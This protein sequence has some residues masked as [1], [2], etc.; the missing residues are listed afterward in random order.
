MRKTAIFPVADPG[1]FKQKLLAW[2]E[3]HEVCAH[4]DSNGYQPLETQNSKLETQNWDCLAAAGVADFVQKQAGEGA[5]AALQQ[6]HDGKRDWLFGMLGYDLKN[7][8]EDLRSE[9][10]DGIGFP[11]LYFF[12]PENVVGL[13]DG[14]AHVFSLRDEPGAVFQNIENQHIEAEVWQPKNQNLQSKIGKADY[15]RIVEQVRRDIALGDFYELN[16][17]QEFFAEGA[18]GPGPAGIF[19]RLNAIGKAPFSAY[20]R[21]GERHLCCAS[22]ERFL[23]KTGDWLASQPI[24]GTR[25]RGQTEAE[26]AALARELAASAKDRSENVM[27]VDLVRND[28]GRVCEPGTVAVTELCGIH[29]FETVLQMISTVVGRLR[30]DAH[31][32]DALRAAFPPGSMTGAPKVMAMQRIERY[33]H[34]RRGLYS[35]SVGYLSP[36]GDFDFNVVIRSVLCNA[37]TGY[38]S[39][40]VGGAIVF[41]S[42][43]EGEYEEC[44]V[45]AGGM[46]RALGVG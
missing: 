12:Q 27:I 23:K 31:W 1:V 34:S 4:L 38:V 18:P 44:L 8:L 11:D 22:P 42:E 32:V 2:A 36:E 7:E 40:Q 37:A 24:K 39:F 15:L 33:E 13:R 3:A 6:L 41:D 35:G 43:P 28:L 5:F 29:R 30:A 21:L 9:H 20:F 46:L 17:C 14:Q 45:K 16:F 26:D 19:R 25:R 10:P